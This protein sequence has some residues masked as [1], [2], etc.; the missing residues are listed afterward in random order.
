MKAVHHMVLPTNPGVGCD[1]LFGFGH[2][3]F[4]LDLMVCLMGST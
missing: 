2:H 3:L 4:W 1:R